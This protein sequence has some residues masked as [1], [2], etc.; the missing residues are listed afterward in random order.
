MNATKPLEDIAREIRKKV[1]LM[2]FHAGGGH[3]GPSMS[4]IE[5]LVTL[6]FRVLRVNKDNYRNDNRDRFVLSK[7]H[8][9]APLYAI[10]AEKGILDA[11]TLNTMCQKDSILGGHPERHLV[12]GIEYSSGSLGHGLSFSAGLALA[13]KLDQKDYRVFAVL[14][15]GECQEG[16]VW[17]AALFAGHHQLDNLVAIIDHNKLQSLDRVENVLNL[18]PF[19]DKW[20]SFGWEVKEVDGHDLSQLGDALS[21]LPFAKDR[22]SVIIAHTVKGKGIS[23]M[24]NTP[25]WH[26]RLPSTREEWSAVCSELDIDKQ[27]LDKVLA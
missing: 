14:S 23:F 12:P 22:P 13:G 3:I 24:E 1:V 26:Y 5:I 16:S 19:G 21:S 10:L 4:C 7:G 25:I 8:A 11:N 17:E 2:C 6:Y 20:K 15:D 18:K 9:C 27:E